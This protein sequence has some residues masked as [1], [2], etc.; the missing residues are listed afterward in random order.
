MYVLAV[1]VRDGSEDTAEIDP[2]AEEGS[3]ESPVLRRSDLDSVRVREK[4]EEA[5][6]ETEKNS[7]SIK[8]GKAVDSDLDSTS[9]HRDSSSD[10]DGGPA[11]E[12][13][14]ERST[15]KHCN[16]GSDIQEARDQLLGLGMNVPSTFDLVVF[17][18]ED[19]EEPD[20]CLEA[21]DCSSVCSNYLSYHTPG[22]VHTKA[23][24][25][26]RHADGAANDET[27]PVVEQ[28]VVPAFADHRKDR[29]WTSLL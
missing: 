15:A 22:G 24:L 8:T 19:L 18:P 14:R 9:N 20:H 28:M 7:A 13:V 2:E 12:L 3:K 21:S 10:P 29:N 23:I 16:N 6:S 5:V 11:T 26:V 27:F 17:V 4:N 25:A 1:V